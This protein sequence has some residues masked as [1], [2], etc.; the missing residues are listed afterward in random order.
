MFDKFTTLT[1]Q[2]STQKQYGGLCLRPVRTKWDEI[3]SEC[4]KFGQALRVIC[5]CNPT[6]VTNDQILI[7]EI[8][9]H[10]GKWDSMAYDDRDFP[11]EHWNNHID[12][13]ELLPVP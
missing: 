4:Q 6:G 5:A 10:M 3:S 9:K 1:P 11:H 2:G 7:M 13:K 8:P 12:Y